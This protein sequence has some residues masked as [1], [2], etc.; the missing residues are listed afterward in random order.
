M[1]LHRQFP[2]QLSNRTE[3]VP[4]HYFVCVRLIPFRPLLSTP[5]YPS[6][7]VS[8]V[9]LQQQPSA[10]Q[11]GFVVSAFSNSLPHCK[12]KVIRQPSRP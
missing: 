7:C 9:L 2:F 5:P 4:L 12:I 8:R 3:P 11:K 1:I 10:L 6:P